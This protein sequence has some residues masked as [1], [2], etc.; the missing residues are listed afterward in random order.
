MTK[1]SMMRTLLL[2]VLIATVGFVET[3][4]PAGAASQTGGVPSLSDRV[5]ALEQV[6]GMLQSQVSA[7]QGQITTLQGANSVGTATI[8]CPDTASSSCL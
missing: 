7:L 5:A 6:A 2:A 3:P 8:G 1:I 4:A